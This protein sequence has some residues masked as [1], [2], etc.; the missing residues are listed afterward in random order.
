MVE[1]GFKGRQSG[2]RA[3][4]LDQGQCDLP[5]YNIDL[6]P[7]ELHLLTNALLNIYIKGKNKD[8]DL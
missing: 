3:H 8:D 7:W 5:S 1:A 4:I 6:H 2:S